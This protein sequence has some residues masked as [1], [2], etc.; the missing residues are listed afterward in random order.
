[1]LNSR[2]PFNY[3]FLCIIL[4]ILSTLNSFAQTCF[5]DVIVNPDTVC[6]A[7]NANLFSSVIA[8]DLKF[9]DSTLYQIPD[10]NPSG[11]ASTILVNL[12]HNLPLSKLKSV[13][14]NIIHPYVQDIEIRL[15]AP[16]GSSIILVNRIVSSGDNY[17]NTQFTNDLLHQLIT[18]GSPPFTGP[19]RPQPD[20]FTNL[21]G[22]I[23]GTWKLLVIDHNT[24]DAGDIIDWELE[25]YNAIITSQWTSIPLPIFSS[26]QIGPHTVW[27]NQTTEFILTISDATN[28]T[29]T[30]SD[31]I[32][33]IN[34]LP[35]TANSPIDICTGKATVTAS[36]GGTGANIQYLWY[37]NDLPANNQFFVGT[38]YTSTF[39]V[40][41]TTFF[42]ATVIDQCTSTSRTPIQILV[43]P[44]ILPPTTLQSPTKGC[45]NQQTLVTA[46][47]GT[48]SV[49][50][51]WFSD[52]IPTGI[53]FHTGKTYLTQP[54]IADTT[55]WLARIENGCTSSARQS[56][57]IQAFTTPNRPNDTTLNPICKGDTITIAPTGSNESYVWYQN[58]ASITPFFIG[59]KYTTSH[60][61]NDTIL[62]VASVWY[63][64]TSLTKTSILVQTRILPAPPQVVTPLKVCS[65]SN[66][67]IVPVPVGFD[68]LFA[69]YSDS[70]TTHPLHIGDTFITH[71][72]ASTDTIWVATINLGCTSNIRSPVILNVLPFPDTPATAPVVNLC[73]INNAFIYAKAK[74]PNATIRWYSDNNPNSLPIFSGNPYR[75]GLLIKDTVLWVESVLP[76]GCRS[77]SRNSV[78]IDVESLPNAPILRDSV[79]TCNGAP[80]IIKP[81][82]NEL[83][84]T[85]LW[86]DKPTGGNL[87]HSGNI[88]I[89][90][91]LFNNTTF[92]VSNS[93]PGCTS[94][95]RVPQFVAVVQPP[96]PAIVEITNACYGNPASLLA[97]GN[98]PQT[99]Y[100]WFK[101]QTDTNALSNHSVFTTGPL[102]RDTIIYVL[103]TLYGCPANARTPVL[104]KVGYL[105]PTPLIQDVTI[106]GGDSITLQAQGGGVMVWWKNESGGIPLDTT[107]KYTT[108]ALYADTPYWLATLD[109]YCSSLRKKVW[110]KINA[111]KPPVLTSPSS[112]CYG[113]RLKLQATPSTGTIHWF[114]QDSNEVAIG[115]SYLTDSLKNITTFRMLTDDGLC[116]S[117]WVNI[118][119]KILPPAHN[120][121]I[122]CPETVAVNNP[123]YIVGDA[124]PAESQL[125][126]NFG[127]GANV[128]QAPPSDR[129]PHFVAITL[130][131]ERTIALNAI[132][133]NCT[134]TFY[135]NITVVPFLSNENKHSFD[136]N[137][138]I[139]P[140]PFNHSFYITGEL[141][142]PQPID[143]EI[144]NLLG[145]KVYSISE[146]NASIL[147]KK[148]DLLDKPS[149]IYIIKIT[150]KSS[151]YIQ[152][153]ILQR[154]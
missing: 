153:I 103:P 104:I 127:I 148:I 9:K 83:G 145:N 34:A 30:A 75:T 97:R 82:S 142:N 80:A 55:F 96:N 72:V 70:I 77:R 107:T 94:A 67:I 113:T 12:P 23:N 27:V 138:T 116:R 146:S 24:G 141:F 62:W 6:K 88:F 73:G 50:Y 101:N 130:V 36:G 74:E 56:V 33:L 21:T 35:P 129:D 81:D 59:K 112:A 10:D 102:Y 140:N 1:M 2:Y 123:F 105:P 76:N 64:C 49:Q 135:K 90:P 122:S 29:A 121:T 95:N 61:Q 126:W 154:Q 119:V 3:S 58:N 108:P 28:C 71:P 44:T 143:I 11:I 45:L 60:L 39:L 106:C 79:W 87:V 86:F 22:T 149:G 37:R 57:K 93:V 66:A 69:F 42:I 14:I 41:D 40:A 25:F 38:T 147:N 46:T 128:G 111:P 20:T 91:P 152:K 17:T 8:P 85:F 131:G 47:G 32:L 89:T 13:K 78:L 15:I 115:N 52:T 19:F 137:I 4:F 51:L 65:L 26:S 98:P 150:T 144:Y 124:Q 48:D 117:I 133:G 134:T 7:G 16:N 43:R 114:D 92:W 120:L 53:Q 151:S 139:S 18:S 132:V 110:V 68:T 118:P 54:L 31:T 100:Y 84:H 125:L 63:H 136:G 109:G 5:L 99:I